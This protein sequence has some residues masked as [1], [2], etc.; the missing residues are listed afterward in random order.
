M[1]WEYKVHKV[2]TGGMNPPNLD[3]FTEK[4]LNG[5]GSNGWELIQVVPLGA[6]GDTRQVYFYFKRPRG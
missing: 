3:N 1:K 5:L 4:D 2:K 6:S